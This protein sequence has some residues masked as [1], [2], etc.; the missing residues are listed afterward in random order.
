MKIKREKGIWTAIANWKGKIVI[1]RFSYLE[2][3]ILWALAVEK[4]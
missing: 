1:G 2:S 3:A 4:R